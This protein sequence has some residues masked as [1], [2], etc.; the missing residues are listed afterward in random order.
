MALRPVSDLGLVDATDAAAPPRGAAEPGVALRRTGSRAKARQ[1]RSSAPS[2]SRDRMSSKASKAG[3]RSSSRVGLADE[4]TVF[5]QVMMPAE[6]HAR[7]TDVSFALAADH[8]KLRHQKTILGALVWRYVHPETG[9]GLD[10]L[11]ALLAAFAASEFLDAPADVKVGAHLPFSLKRSLDGAAL[12][13]K[14]R[15]RRDASVKL[16]VAA[17]VFEHVRPEHPEALVELLA[18]YY[19]ELE[20]TRPRRSSPARQP[21]GVLS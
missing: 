9:A 18:A 14:R 3:D 8:P 6:L 4:Q 2:S 5:V 1:R 16:L 19:A 7:L 10:G 13:L 21:A 12:A 20:P 11:E 15:Y 17:L